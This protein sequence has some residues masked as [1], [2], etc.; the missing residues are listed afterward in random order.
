MIK[1]LVVVTA[2]AI[3]G[4]SALASLGVVVG[5][6]A[7]HGTIDACVSVKGTLRFSSTAPAPPHCA[8][9]QNSVAVN[10]GDNSTAAA[11]GGNKNIAAAVGPD[12]G[13]S[14]GSGNRNSAIAVGA[15]TTATAGSGNHN[16]AVSARAGCPPVSVSGGDHLIDHCP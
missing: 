7:A 1:R 11:G 2:L 9:D 8:S 14:A 5:G 3:A 15:A 4:A 6:S 10:V 16:T 12:A 13:T